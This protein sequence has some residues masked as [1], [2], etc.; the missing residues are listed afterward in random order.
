MIPALSEIGGRC[1]DAP[2]AWYLARMGPARTANATG[3]PD[4]IPIEVHL[5]ARE[6]LDARAA[7]RARGLLVQRRAEHGRHRQ[8]LEVDAAV[9]DTPDAGLDDDEAGREGGLLAASAGD[10]VRGRN[11]DDVVDDGAVGVGHAGQR[12][13]LVEDRLGQIDGAVVVREHDDAGDELLILRGVAGDVL[14]S[15]RRLADGHARVDELPPLLAD[16]RRLVGKQVSSDR[17]NLVLSG[18]VLAAGGERRH[19]EQDGCNLNR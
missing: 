11:A 3:A 7:D 12:L 8:V 5:T 4:G 1:R 19:R 18:L 2:L 17:D 16:R 9:D 14:N 6:R 15:R 10:I 13:P